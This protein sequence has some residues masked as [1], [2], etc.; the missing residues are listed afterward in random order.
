[1]AWFIALLVGLALQVVAYLLM[2]KPKQAKPPAAQDL[3]DPTAEAGR[4]IPVVF[5][6]IT[7]KGINVIHYSDKLVREYKISV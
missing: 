5:G 2:P 4:P 6:T 3:E 7:V 1:M